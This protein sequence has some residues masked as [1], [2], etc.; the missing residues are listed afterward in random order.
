MNAKIEN[1]RSGGALNVIAKIQDCP[2]YVDILDD[3]ISFGDVLAG[4]SKWS[5]DSFKIKVL[6]SSDKPV[7]DKITWRIEFD[8]SSGK[9]HVIENVSMFPKF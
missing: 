3:Q 4:E 5:E 7:N 2:D 6:I 9:H 8:D 1:I